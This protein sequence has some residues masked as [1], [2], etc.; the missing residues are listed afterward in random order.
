MEYRRVIVGRH[1]PP[2]VLQVER[3]PLPEPGPGEAR[4][5]VRAAGVAFADLLM[6]HGIYPGTPKPPF[7]PGYDIAGI[8]DRLGPG[9]DHVR[10]GDPV[11]ALTVRGGYAEF[12]IVPSA[13]LIAAP[14]DI[15]PAEATSL[16]LNYGTA[17]QLLHRQAAVTRGETVLVHG[18]AGG[19]GTALLQLGTLAGLELF[20]TASPTKHALVRQHGATP[21][22]YRSE[23]FVS[24]LRGSASGGADAVFDGVGGRNA[25]RS[26]RA[27]LRGGRLVCYGATSAVRGTRASAPTLYGTVALTSLLN[28]LPD[29][30]RAR[31]YSIEHERRAHPEA[32]RQDLRTLLD[33]LAEGRLRPVIA[34]RLRL[35]EAPR[36]HRLLE[37]GRVLGKLVLLC[38]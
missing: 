36:A 10:E 23:D 16:V 8:V 38:E 20:G 27:L 5:R 26:Y 29:G 37:E 34:D 31:F 32:F 7:V 13:D 4:V 11:V 30:R 1:G 25:W 17:H 21:I 28:A 18:A 24:R 35:E 2:E 14:P 22:D 9:V 15:D 19:V 3:A 12:A 33:L 6:R